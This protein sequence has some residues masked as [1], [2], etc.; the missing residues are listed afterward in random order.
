MAPPCLN[1]LVPVSS[2]SAVV[3]HTSAAC[4]ALPPVNYRPSLF[5]GCSFHHLEHSAAQRPIITDY[6]NFSSSSKD[7]SVS[8]VISWYHPL[9]MGGVC[10]MFKVF[11]EYP[12]N[13]GCGCIS[14]FSVNLSFYKTLTIQFCYF[15]PAKSPLFGL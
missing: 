12:V 9:T 10:I 4:P 13:L 2:P 7:I 14:M 8:A 5:S 3:I 6:F 1:Q 11:I 15:F